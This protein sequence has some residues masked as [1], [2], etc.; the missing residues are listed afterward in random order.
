MDRLS[1]SAQRGAQ[2]VPVELETGSDDDEFRVDAR[3]HLAAL[4][5]GAAIDHLDGIDRRQVLDPGVDVFRLYNPAVLERTHVR[6]NHD[7]APHVSLYVFDDFWKRPPV[8]DERDETPTTPGIARARVR[9]RCHCEHDERYPPKRSYRRPG[10]RGHISLD[11]D[12]L[13][14]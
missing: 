5:V 8:I 12:S 14:S 2:I 11:S 7:P 6:A 3:R 1:S 4:A 10:S 13:R 9:E